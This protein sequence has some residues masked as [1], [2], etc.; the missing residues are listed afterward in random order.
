MKKMLFVMLAA[1]ALFAMPAMAQKVKIGISIPSADHGWTGG[2]VYYAQ[3]AI[4]DI[5]AKDKSVEFTL[6]LADSPQ[7]QV[8]D[9][10]DLMVKGI[11]ALVVL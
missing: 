7:K 5:K 1:L 3:M 11:N 8:S 9:V 2:L 4:R 6:A 10:E